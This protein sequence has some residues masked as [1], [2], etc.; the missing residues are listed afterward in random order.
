MPLR[1]RFW[2]TQLPRVF[3]PGRSQDSQIKMQLGFGQSKIYFGILKC[4]KA[5]LAKLFG[6]LFPQVA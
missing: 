3:R 4:C 1:V 5:C 2:T 6:I